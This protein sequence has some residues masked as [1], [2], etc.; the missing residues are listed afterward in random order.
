MCREEQLAATEFGVDENPIG[1][2]PRRMTQADLRALGHQSMSATAAIRSHCLDCCAG[3]ADE[4]RKCMALKCPSWPWRM[5]VNPWRTRASERQREA[6]RATAARINAERTK[7]RSGLAPTDNSLPPVK[8]ASRSRNLL[9]SDIE[10]RFVCALCEHDR[11]QRRAL[12]LLD[13]ARTG[14]VRL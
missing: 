4:V 7:S 14:S 2:D 5:G 11:Q 12:A 10:R 9:P 6:A 3:S 8:Q 13:V 1:R